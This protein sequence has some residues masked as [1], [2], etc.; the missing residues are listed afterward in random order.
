MKFRLKGHESFIPREGWIT[1]GLEAVAVN[2]QIFSAQNYYGADD[3][4]VG[5]NMAKSIRY[6]LHAMGLANRNKAGEYITELGQLVLEKDPYI[7]EDFTM[8][9]LHYNLVNNR[10]GATSWYLYFQTTLEEEY[11]RVELYQYLSMRLE[12]ELGVGKYAKTSLMDDVNAIINMYCRTLGRDLEVDPEEKAICPFTGLGLIQQNGH[13]YINSE[14]DY[15][16]FPELMVLYAISQMLNK[17]YGEDD[18]IQQ[19]IVSLSIEKLQN[20]VGGVRNTFHMSGVMLNDYL[21]RLEQQSFIQV[22]R[23]AGLDILYMTKQ[24]PLTA[25]EVART[26]YGE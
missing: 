2:P 9:M 14:P 17:Q 4:G 3:L 1:K 15:E 16:K 26:Y 18:S 7:E 12:R 11:D 22:N 23:T 8:W 10:E 19:E 20:G 24:T 13:H 6:W 5:T 21:D 25:V